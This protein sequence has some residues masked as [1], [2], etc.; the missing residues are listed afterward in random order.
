VKG[1]NRGLP[2]TLQVRRSLGLVAAIFLAHVLAGIGLWPAAVPLALKAA[3]WVALAISLA[4]FVRRRPVAALTLNA[5]GQLSLFR[6]DGSSVECRI[7]PATT[8]FPWLVVLLV[9]TVEKTEALVLPV[10]ALGAEGHRQLRI[11]LKWKANVGQA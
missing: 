1:R 9:K 5:N 7:D 8:I 6:V 4:M 2:V 10:D 11:W 3:V